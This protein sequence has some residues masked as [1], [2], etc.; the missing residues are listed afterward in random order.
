ME[1]QLQAVGMIEFNSIAG[2][3]EGADYMVKAQPVMVA[4]RDAE[5]PGQV[6]EI[7][8]PAPP[9][10]EHRTPPRAEPIPPELMDDQNQEEANP[11]SDTGRAGDRVEVTICEQS[12]LLAGPGCPSPVVVGFDLS[13]GHRPPSKVCATRAA[14]ACS[15]RTRSSMCR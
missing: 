13:A 9:R 3:I 11:T 6:E 2:G 10:E 7:K 14:A 1:S 15:A 5:H 4:S 12:G 8:P